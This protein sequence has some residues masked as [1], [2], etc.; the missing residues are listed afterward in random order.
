[1]HEYS[2]ESYDN[3]VVKP[4]QSFAQPTQK[5]VFHW[6]FVDFLMTFTETSFN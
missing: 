3:F 1:M 5:F 4:K 6:H 2:V